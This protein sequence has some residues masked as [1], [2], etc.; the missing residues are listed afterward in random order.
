MTENVRIRKLDQEKE[1]QRIWVRQ[2]IMTRIIN[3]GRRVYNYFFLR[4]L[5]RY[6]TSE[7]RLLELGSGTSSLL[8]QL[9]PNVKEVVGLDITKASIDL[10]ENA[11]HEA[12]ISN[13]HFI[14]GDCLTYPFEPTYDIVW[15]QGLMEHFQN[16]EDIA[17]AHLRALKPGGTALIS[18]P[19]RYSY[20]TIWYLL[21]R[22]RILRPLWPWTDQVFYN[23]R[24][25]AEIG[26]KVTP[27]VRTFL[28]YPFFLG[29][30][31]VELKK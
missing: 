30:A 13:A 23:K 4:M 11:A 19:Y 18:V 26:A 6:V 5:S 24:M 22:P 14:L 31:I 2:G 15:S 29:I 17:K 21:T 25:L 8:M 9:A 27:H 10:S 12:G 16:P 1:W 7:T 20:H 3:A 28:L